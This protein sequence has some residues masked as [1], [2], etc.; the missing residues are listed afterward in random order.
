MSHRVIISDAAKRDLRHLDKVLQQRVAAR[1]QTLAIEP[2]P[3]GVLKLRGRE[4]QWR[5][6]VGDYRI[7]YE[8]DDAAKL[9]RIL[10]IAHRRE[11]YR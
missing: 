8:V 9:V 4:N 10:R 2:R 5:L 6:R 7:L 11:V 3:P 1:L